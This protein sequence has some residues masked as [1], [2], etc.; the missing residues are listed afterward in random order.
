V[1]NTYNIRKDGKHILGFSTAE[2]RRNDKSTHISVVDFYFYFFL[3]K[4][5]KGFFIL[6]MTRLD[7]GVTW[8]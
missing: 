6:F 1:Q 8:I 2:Q 3:I 5:K 7:N 4:N